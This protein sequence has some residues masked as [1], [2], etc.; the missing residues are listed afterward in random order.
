[1]TSTTFVQFQTPIN[2]DWLNDVNTGTY[3]DPDVFTATA[4]QTVFTLTATPPAKPKA[5]LNGLRLTP[6]TDYSISGTTLTLVSAAS[7][8]DELLVDF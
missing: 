2:A 3:R 4:G 7:V 6:T 1:M 8:G 5:F